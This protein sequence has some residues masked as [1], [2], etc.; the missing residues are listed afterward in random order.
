MDC[1]VLPDAQE[2]ENLVLR[3]EETEDLAEVLDQL[4]EENRALLD[5]RY[6]MGMTAQEIAE[7]QGKRPGSVRMALTRARRE[8]LRLYLEKMKEKDR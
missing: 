7:E 6:F 4:S 1:A 8:V 2:L 5:K 3:W